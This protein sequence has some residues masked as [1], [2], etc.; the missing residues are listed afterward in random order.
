M[1][2]FKQTARKYCTG[3][4]RAKFAKGIGKRKSA[5]KELL[6]VKIG[7]FSKNQVPSD[8]EDAPANWHDLTPSLPS[9]PEVETFVNQLNEEHETVV[10]ANTPPHSPPQEA[11]IRETLQELDVPVMEKQS[12]RSSRPLPIL[13]TPPRSPFEEGMIE[14]L[15][16]QNPPVEVPVSA[17][18]SSTME[19]VDVSS[20]PK[21]RSQE[22]AGEPSGEYS[23][24]P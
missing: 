9:S 5:A 18:V 22:E 21:E 2:Q 12:E 24:D 17:E 23:N 19:N 13:H 14:D 3:L 7:K 10:R 4:P 8:G 6:K 20:Q 15:P 1:V 16:V 11:T